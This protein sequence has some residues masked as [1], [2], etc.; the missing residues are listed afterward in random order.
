MPGDM[1][2]RFA[3]L[4]LLYSYMWTH[5][6]KKLLFMGGE[7]GQW[8]EWDCDNQLQWD[9]LQWD[10][11]QGIK[12]TVADLNRLYRK[13]PSLHE[14]DFEYTGFEWI[15]CH[16]YDDSTLAYIR[17]A[18]DPS[19]FVAVAC[20]F[21]PVARHAYRL[22]VPQLC[23]YEEVFNSD[24]A[25]YGGGKVG[26]GPG[27]MADATESHGRPASVEITLPPLATVVLKPRR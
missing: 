7:F 4:R 23:W 15:D 27:V 24:S 11:H 2:Q 8:W 1:W 13:E 12:A 6:G 9:L 20:N 19:D 18:E 26:N 10:T 21:T 22:G 16:D 17:R 3:N 14:V 25:F 5:P